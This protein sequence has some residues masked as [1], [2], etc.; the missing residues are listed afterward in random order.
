MD[1]LLDQSNRNAILGALKKLPEGFE[2]TYHNALE[3]I[4]QQSLNRKRMAYRLLSWISYAFRPLSLTELRYAVAL[5]EDIS[6]MDEDY[7]DDEEFLIS[8]CA[9]LV[10]VSKESH[11]VGLVRRSFAH[12]LIQACLQN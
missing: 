1:S 7:L 4:N 3:R 10:T 8:V 9:G 12:I 2:A 6:I 5:R 11:Q